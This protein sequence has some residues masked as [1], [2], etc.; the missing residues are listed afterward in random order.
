MG[1][2][3]PCYSVNPL[4]ASTEYAVIQRY[5]EADTRSASPGFD[6]VLGQPF[7]HDI[8]DDQI[9]E[10]QKVE[11]QVIVLAK[12]SNRRLKEQ[13]QTQVGNAP[14]SFVE[15][16]LYASNLEDEGLLANGTCGIRANDRLIR[17]QDADGNV[18]IDFT[19]D[20]SDGLK[21]IGVDFGETG[22]GKL[23]ANFESPR[24]V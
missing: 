19:S 22:T 1:F 11:N 10:L 2:L 17:I 21:C 18:R 23:T 9:G 20:G 12:Y 15:L 24:Q 16:T 8:N 14:R 7:L 13:E 6:D 3:K 4:T 5:M